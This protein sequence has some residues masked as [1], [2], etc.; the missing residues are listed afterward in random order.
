LARPG[1]PAD[2]GAEPGRIV[3]AGAGRFELSG[4]VGFADAAR[5]L[6]EGD[7]AFRGLA[8]VEVDLA[9]VTRVDSA[10]LALLLEWSLAAQDAGRALAYRN[11]PPAIASLAGISDVAPLLAPVPGG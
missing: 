2:A 8:Q 1:R 3:A 11:V 5:L 6:A 4:D 7:A 10:G 9:R